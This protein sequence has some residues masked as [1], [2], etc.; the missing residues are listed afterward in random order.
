MVKIKLWA[1]APGQLALQVADNGAGFDP[2]A[3]SPNGHYGL[4]NMRKRAAEIGA[5]L[6]IDSQPGTGTRVTVTL[7]G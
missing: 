6:T 7:G 1:P 3:G 4:A 2:A 5:Q